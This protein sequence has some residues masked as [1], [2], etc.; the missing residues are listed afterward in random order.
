MRTSDINL[1]RRNPFMTCRFFQTPRPRGVLRAPQLSL[2]LPGDQLIGELCRL[3]PR[4]EGVQGEARTPLQV[5]EEVRGCV[6][7]REIVPSITTSGQ[8]QDFS[9]QTR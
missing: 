2:L 9:G 8:N 7:R 4:R 6:N 1:T 5:Q 3:L